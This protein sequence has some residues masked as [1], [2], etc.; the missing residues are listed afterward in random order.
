M[1]FVHGYDLEY[2]DQNGRP[3]VRVRFVP[4]GGRRR[5]FEKHLTYLE[6]GKTRT[7]SYSN[8][9]S[10]KVGDRVKITTR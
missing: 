7:F 3:Y 4:V 9:T 6:D 10:Y 5:A 8:P 2:P 1:G